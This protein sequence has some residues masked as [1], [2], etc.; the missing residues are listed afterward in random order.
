MEPRWIG[1]FELVE[2]IGEGGMGVVYRARYVGNN[3]QVA[4]KL[5][6]NDITANSTTLARFERELEVLKQLSHPNIVHCFGGRCE[7]KQ[8]YYA[9]EYI[10]GGT[11][12]DLLA[13]KGPLPWETVVDFGIQMCD[14]LQYAHE[15]GV[16]HRDVKPGNFLLTK[17]G[18][19]KLSDF[20]LASI[21]SQNRLTASDRT[22]G[23]ILYMSPEQIRGEL[24]TNR[25][26]LYGLGCVL[27]E[28]MAGFTPF[29]GST[30]GEVLQTVF[31]TQPQ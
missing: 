15:R 10:P 9:M 26:D 28:M 4:V 29:V 12:A 2:K 5:I 30:A 19:L 8:R 24:V 20:G 17:S 13:E 22:V 23:T 1:P 7:S 18:Q 6:P 14:A 16:T 21:V 3:R 25:V 11:L 31:V 27:F